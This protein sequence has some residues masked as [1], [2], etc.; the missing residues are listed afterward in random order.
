MT[1]NIP[2]ST[3]NMKARGADYSV[4]EALFFSIKSAFD[5]IKNKGRVLFNLMLAYSLI[6]S[7]AAF[8]LACLILYAGNLLFRD[9]PVPWDQLPL[10]LSESSRITRHLAD[11]SMELFLIFS[12]LAAIYLASQLNEK[13][14][15]TLSL[16]NLYRQSKKSDIGRIALLTMGFAIL[17]LLTYNE[18]QNIALLNSNSGYYDEEIT[19]M[20]LFKWI[21]VMC[22]KL[23]YYSAFPLA[24]SIYIRHFTHTGPLQSFRKF[25]KSFV[26]SFIMILSAMVLSEFLYDELKNTL[27][28]I[29][30]LNPFLMII[31]GII[32]L[33]L[34]ITLSSVMLMIICAGFIYPVS[35][36]LSVEEIAAT[37]EMT[38]SM[39]PNAAPPEVES[40]V[41]DLEEE[42]DEQNESG[43]DENYPAN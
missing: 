1:E 32:K 10:I 5:L 22:S 33:V 36:Q 31:G 42:E 8:I 18:F 11:L 39:D 28:S 30:E 14:L 34:I 24:F 7:S 43:S 27:L 2:D 20:N 19:R 29:T 3:K 41:Q 21:Y 25:K 40:L 35:Y 37:D 23:L 6:S 16:G 13:D 9:N 38:G 12:S 15:S 17:H 26:V 4:Y